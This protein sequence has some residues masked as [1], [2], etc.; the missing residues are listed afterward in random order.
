MPPQQNLWVI[1]PDARSQSV[2]DN[3]CIKKPELT[4]NLLFTSRQNHQSLAAQ[5]IDQAPGPL[6]QTCFESRLRGSEYSTG[7]LPVNDL[8][9]ALAQ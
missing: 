7:I 1:S 5:R 6:G 4:N 3:R 8:E 2:R 9:S